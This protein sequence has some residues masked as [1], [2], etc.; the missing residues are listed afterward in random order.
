MTTLSSAVLM[1]VLPSFR[2]QAATPVLCIVT[3]VIVCVRFLSAMSPTVSALSAE[4]RF[5]AESVLDPRSVVVSPTGTEILS[6]M[7]HMAM[8]SETLV[9]R[10]TQFR[11]V[12]TFLTQSMSAVFLSVALST[13]KGA[14][15]VPVN[16][17]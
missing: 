13:A 10:V 7:A 9:V 15:Y 1:S 4:V 3:S 6:A 14:V 16:V 8:T 12:T 5:P 2:D 11:T 17:S